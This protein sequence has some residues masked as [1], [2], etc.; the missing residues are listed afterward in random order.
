MASGCAVSNIAA[1]AFAFPR[2]G[3]LCTVVPLHRRT[4]SLLL[5]VILILVLKLILPFLHLLLV[6]LMLVVLMSGD[7]AANCADH[8]MVRHMTSDSPSHT[9]SETADGTSR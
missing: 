6:N 5:C 1:P 3:P 9:T 2:S 4:L 8:A 7:A